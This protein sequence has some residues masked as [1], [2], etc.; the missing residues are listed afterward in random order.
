MIIL[1]VIVL[2]IF[3]VPGVRIIINVIKSKKKCTEYADATVV[4][5][6]TRYNRRG[7]VSYYPVFKYEFDGVDHRRASSFYSEFL[8]FNVGDKTG[9]YIDPDNPEMFYCPKETIQ[10][11]IAN[12]IICGERAFVVLII[13]FKFGIKNYI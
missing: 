13:Y 7:R 12:L 1:I 2:L 6:E 4:D 9:L 11:V 10:K 8:G 5:F 3:L